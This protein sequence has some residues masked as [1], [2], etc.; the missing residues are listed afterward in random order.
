MNTVLLIN[1]IKIRWIAIVGQLTTL[2]TI[3]FV[4]NFTIPLTECLIVVALSI[5]VNFY[6]YFIQRGNPTLTDKKTFLFLLFDISQLVGLLFLTGGVFNPFLVLIVAPIIISASYLS[7]LWTILLS[8]YSILLILIINFNYI[9]LNWDQ[10]FITPRIYNIG[11]VIALI[12]TI[13]FIAIYA[14]LFASSARKISRALTATELKL[15]NQKK[16][17]EVAYLS[18]AAVHELSTPLNTIFLVLNDLL[19]EKILIT[20]S[21]LIKDIELLKSQAERCKEILLRLS[22]NPQNLKDNFFE[23][24][25]IIDLIKLNFEKFNDNKK[26]ILNNDGF[27]K[28]N[29]I[30]F[31]DE[32]NYALG[33]IIQNSILYSKVEIKIFLKVNK[34]VFTIKIEDDGDGF[35]RDVLDKLGEP[36]ISKNKKGMGLGI[37]IAKNLI[38]NMKGNIIFY[39]SNNNGAVVEINFDKT[40]LI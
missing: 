18:A 4:F 14:Y 23:K 13:I 17:T 21:V 37:F 36:Y 31:K 11:I 12:I 16:T 3:F 29:K 9:P 26:L 34:S 32:V 28:E 20:N 2:F 8:L 27:N 7:A 33:N 24:I 40:I 15:S 35:S 38:E 5:L 22:K 39:N 10:N 1:L 6:S 30:L 19:K 25:R